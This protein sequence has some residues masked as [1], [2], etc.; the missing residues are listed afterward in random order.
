LEARNPSSSSPSPV[1][2]DAVV[3]RARAALEEGRVEDALECVAE[4]WRLS[5][6]VQLADVAQQLAMRR[7]TPLCAQL[8]GA[9]GGTAQASLARVVALRGLDHPLA[10]T[11]VLEQLLVP[12]FIGKTAVPLLDELIAQ[13]LALRDPRLRAAAPRIGSMLEV[14]MKHERLWRPLVARLVNGVKTIPQLQT[15]HAEQA[16]TALEATRRAT[17][18]VDTLLQD[19]CANPHDDALRLQLAERLIARCDPRGEFVQ[20]QCR[21]VDA[22]RQQRLLKQHRKRWLGL[23]APL[24]EAEACRFERGFLTHVVLKGGYGIDGAVALSARDPIWSTVETIEGI[25]PE[26]LLW[27]AALS[28]LRYV[29]IGVSVV[30]RLATAHRRFSSVRT[31]ALIGCLDW[32]ATTQALCTVFPRLQEL[33]LTAAL[34]EDLDKVMHAVATPVPGLEQIVINARL[35]DALWL[36][37]LARI[38]ATPARVAAVVASRCVD[39]RPPT[40]AVVFRQHNGRYEQKPSVLTSDASSDSA[41]KRAQDG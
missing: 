28:A 18:D 30:M 4:A 40:T 39:H 2:A 14:R 13:G 37:L 38:A 36:E 20:L 12:R 24:V 16:T 10:A 19:I 25:G 5:R 3:E 34:P 29:D 41:G 6:S 9:V 35:Q 23:L 33:Q 17:V 26:W 8:A 15:E 11:F 31:V 27:D 32:S 21:N 7:P 1:P 22:A